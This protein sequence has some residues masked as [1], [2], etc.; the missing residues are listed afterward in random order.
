[1]GIQVDTDALSQAARGY[2]DAASAVQALN[3]GLSSALDQ[4]AAA[5]ANDHVAA[6]TAS[7]HTGLTTALRTLADSS[8]HYATKVTQAAARYRAADA[9]PGQ[10][11]QQQP[12]ADPPANTRGL[13][14]GTPHDTGLLHYASL[15]EAPPMRG[16]GRAGIVAAL[17]A[18]LLQ[19]SMSKPGAPPQQPPSAATKPPTTAAAQP[20]GEEPPGDGKPASRP[21]R[22]P[23]EGSTDG[24]PGRWTRVNRGGSDQSKAYQESATGVRRGY[25]Y[26]V[27]GVDFDGYENG[28]LIETKADYS[29]FLD[30][31]GGWKWFF[32]SV[33]R[34]GAS[35]SGLD[36]ML[37]QARA[38]LQAA[39]YT[40]VE[41]R[42]ATNELR[43]AL[44]QSLAENNISGI[45]VIVWAP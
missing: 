4:V 36:S 33:T 32:R 42:V 14:A 25:E 19:H 29:S 8:N 7:L 37:S 13:T 15:T 3:G 34:Q 39:G 28:R 12:A 11:I 43:V 30:G 21:L 6:G 18:W 31:N 41:W 2:Q 45:D 9:L 16:A 5:A 1:V 22:Q 23:K 24:G 10:A 26:R 17:L 40:P 44:R 27:N 38:Q 35:Q 20:P